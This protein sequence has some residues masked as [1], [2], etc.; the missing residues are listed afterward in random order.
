M[1]E[2]RN[3]FI[4]TEE[5]KLHYI[6]HWRING[7]GHNAFESNYLLARRN[8]KRIIPF[9]IFRR[10]FRMAKAQIIQ[11]VWLVFVFWCQ[12][13][14]TWDLYCNIFPQ[15]F[16]SPKPPLS[17]CKPCRH[18]VAVDCPAHNGATCPVLTSED[19]CTDSFGHHWS[20]SPHRPAEALHLDQIWFC[21]LCEWSQ[22]KNID[23]IG[24]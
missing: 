1:I 14:Y 24:M 18:E 4:S 21:P 3:C 20:N 11:H 12:E 7:G 13:L 15:H 19:L 10:A 16:S 17:N 2:L 23:N 22:L 9:E 5:A 8:N 6:W